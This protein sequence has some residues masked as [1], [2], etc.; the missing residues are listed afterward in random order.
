LTD[1]LQ[2]ALS[3]FRQEFKSIQY[4]KTEKIRPKVRFIEMNHGKRGGEFWRANYELRI[5]LYHQS[6]RTWG[7]G[8]VVISFLFFLEPSVE[9]VE[10]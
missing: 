2:A 3:K 9:Y 4:K 6:D 7:I 8:Y 10:N 5:L 1:D